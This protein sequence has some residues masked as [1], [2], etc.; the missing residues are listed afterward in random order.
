M[1]F[2][3]AKQNRK[4]IELYANRAQHGCSG[5]SRYETSVC[6][7]VRR[8][9]AHTGMLIKSSNGY[10]L[11]THF[12]KVRKRNTHKNR[13]ICIKDRETI[14]AEHRRMNKRSKIQR[15][16]A[17][18]PIA[19]YAKSPFPSFNARIAVTIASVCEFYCGHLN[20]QCTQ[21][22]Y[23][24]SIYPLCCDRTTENAFLLFC[25]LF[26]LRVYRSGK[27]VPANQ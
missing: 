21:F 23:A 19:V 24:N 27:K 3:K 6:E 7:C 15:T 12:R 18:R 5:N 11:I 22:A 16:A 1:H 26:T 25:L 9:R 17:Y 4:P 2:T 13:T 8:H 20:S 14:V 10:V